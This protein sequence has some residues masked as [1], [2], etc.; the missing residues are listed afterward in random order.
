MRRLLIVA[1]GCILLS[2][3]SAPNLSYYIIDMTSSGA[4][5]GS[6]NLG[7]GRFV[8]S[9][10]LDR[11]QI[12]IQESP[13]KIGYYATDRWASNIA[14]MV[15]QKLVSEF[16]PVDGER[17]SLIVEGRVVA[18][19]QIDTAAGPVAKAGLEV[20][21]R[22]GESKRY[23]APLLEKSYE[24]ERPASNNSVDAVVRALSRALEAIA[25]EIAA[26]AAEL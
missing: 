19:E 4:S 12:V 3:A 2:C 10:K 22:D 8:V 7:V 21:V 15:E 18:L 5:G 13:T 17:R 23:E 6:A 26:D 16:G 24:V 9:N 14:E 1:L 25:A 11:H 20:V